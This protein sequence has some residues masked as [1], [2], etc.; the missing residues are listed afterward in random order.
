MTDLG[1]DDGGTT[2]IAGTHKV[3]QDVPQEEIV[4]AALEDPSLIHQVEAPAGST[5]LFYESLIHAAGIIR[6]DCDRLLIL[7]GYMP[8]MFQAWMGYEPD[9]DFV[10]TLP[11]E[12]RQLLTGEQKFH[13]P[14][15]PRQLGDPSAV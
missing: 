2:V 6:S 14:R 13:W 1:P 15:Q 10:Q 9:P 7:G 11:D 5:L 8:T 4:A 12:H 3:P